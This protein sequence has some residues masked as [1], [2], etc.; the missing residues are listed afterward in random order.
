MIPRTRN[1]KYSL[2]VLLFALG[3]YPAGVP[4]DE[5]IMRNGDKLTGTVI[6]KQGNVLKF[7]TPYADSIEIRW[8]RVA[9]LRTDKPVTLLLLDGTIVEATFITTKSDADEAE[10]REDGKPVIL[11]GSVGLIKPEPWQIAR[12]AKF[13]GKVNIGLKSERGNTDTDELYLSGEF[14]VRRVQDRF[15]TFGRIDQDRAQSKKTTDKWDINSKY[16][17]FFTKKFY[18][19][20]NLSFESD[21]FADLDLRAT[22]G[23]GLGYQFFESK[24]LNLKLEGGVNY[25]DEN[26]IDPEDRINTEDNTDTEDRE[27]TAL[28]WF[29]EY[30]QYFFEDVIQLYHRQRGLWDLEISKNYN[31]RSWTGLRFP[32]RAGFNFST[33]VQADWDN[34]PAVG[35]DELDTTYRFLL[36]YEW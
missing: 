23:L 26:Y 30:D 20:G 9:S 8:A 15:N 36:G 17:Y 28:R 35:A 4:A 3:F 19:T 1:L 21:F 27:Y 31:F 29:I 24:E 18:Y 11:A 33:E 7:R 22:A 34:T 13:T 16:D 2:L 32:L 10:Q 14:T 12:G 5:L 25:V 6:S